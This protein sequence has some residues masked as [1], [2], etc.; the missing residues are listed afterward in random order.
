MTTGTFLRSATRINECLSGCKVSV[1]LFFV[2]CFSLIDKRMA[3][4]TQ[5]YSILDIENQ[6]WKIYLAFDMV[7][8]KSCFASVSTTNNTTI[9]VTFVNSFSPISPLLCGLDSI[10]S[11]FTKF[12][13]F[14][15][16][17]ALV[18]GTET[19]SHFASF[20]QFIGLSVGILYASGKGNGFAHCSW[21][22][23]LTLEGSNKRLWS[24]A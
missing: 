24:Y 14:R 18:S 4:M 21:L 9:A 2:F 13:P 23:S 16:I 1:K 3:R 11:C 19:S 22:N 17:D 10:P 12:N 5:G 15:L 20:S 8:A 7:R 6:F